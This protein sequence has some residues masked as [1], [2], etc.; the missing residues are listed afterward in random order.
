MW[1]LA[2]SL[3]IGVAL[4][5][6]VQPATAADASAPE[7]A[8]RSIQQLIGMMC[9][10]MW[11]ARDAERVLQV[12]ATMTEVAAAATAI[13]QRAVADADGMRG[14]YDAINARADVLQAEREF[15]LS[16]SPGRVRRGGLTSLLEQRDEALQLKYQEGIGLEHRISRLQRQVLEAGDVTGRPLSPR[17]RQLLQQTL[18]DVTVHVIQ[19]VNRL[20][21]GDN[22][23]VDASGRTGR[24]IQA[25]LNGVQSSNVPAF[26]ATLGALMGRVPASPIAAILDTLESEMASTRRQLASERAADDAVRVARVAE[27]DRQLRELDEQRRP[28]LKGSDD[29]LRDARRWRGVAVIW[30]LA[31]ARVQDCARDQLAWLRSQGVATGAPT[32]PTDA[33]GAT[34]VA[35]AGS[36][37]GSIA[38]AWASS[39]T[40]NGKP[41]G[42]PAGRFSLAVD[43][44]GSIT[45][46]FVEGATSAIAGSVNARGQLFGIGS[47]VMNGTRLQL[48][49]HGTVLRKPAGGISGRGG[50]E[51]T[52]GAGVVCTGQWEG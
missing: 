45:G 13:G 48:S 44:R 34:G 37:A 40:H 30:N 14:N 6:G 21:T 50:F 7:E 17:E 38:G 33:P 2:G 8:P 5:S 18:G 36:W 23:G 24:D 26:A 16:S 47:Y 4:A 12:Q 39:C 46:A 35:G 42:T 3:I 11:A 15:L 31:L 49:L 20:V 32:P 1:H 52:D 19:S 22:R 29:V 10:E 51:S 41:L 28:I 25:E 27:I 9:S 43:A